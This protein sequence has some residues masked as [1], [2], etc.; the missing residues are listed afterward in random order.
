MQSK[1][2]DIGPTKNAL[3]YRGGKVIREIIELGWSE[4]QLRH[5]TLMNFVLSLFLTNQ[6]IP[7]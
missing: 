3:G 5:R 2:P 7:Q 6:S 4:Y 1:S